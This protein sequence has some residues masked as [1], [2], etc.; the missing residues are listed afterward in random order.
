M[1]PWDIGKYR[2]ASA[3]E[4]VIRKAVGAGLTAVAGFNRKRL[5]RVAA[6]PFLTG[7]HQPMTEEKTLSELAVTGTIPPELDG[8]YV[9]IGPNP[10]APDPASYHWFIGDGMVHGVRIKDGKALWYK[11]R[12]TRSDGVTAALGEPPIPGPRAFRGQTVNTNVLGHAGKIWAL[13]EAGNFPIELSDELASVAFNP[14]E[15]TLAG[16][17][18]AHPHLDPDTGEMHAICYRGDD[19]NDRDDDHQRQPYLRHHALG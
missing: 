17:F 2:M 16:S 14:F 5:P 4:T 13:V 19:A 12:W 9:R 15:G 6:H 3:V 8:R 18:S 7:I 11:N 10:I 1:M